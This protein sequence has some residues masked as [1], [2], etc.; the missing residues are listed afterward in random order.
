MQ[1]LMPE[2]RQTLK[3]GR[4]FRI[5]MKQYD[6]RLHAN[7]MQF[8]HQTLQRSATRSRFSVVRIH[9][10]LQPHAGVLV[11]NFRTASSPRALSAP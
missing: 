2:F 9:G 7:R 1:S 5:F 4:E 11:S 6:Q 10:H 8:P 3:I